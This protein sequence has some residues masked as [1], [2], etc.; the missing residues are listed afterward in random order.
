MLLTLDVGNTQVYAGIYDGDTIRARF[1]MMTG[2]NTSSDELGVFLRQAL[3]E[4]DI[5]PALV[6]GVAVSS[7]VPAFTRSIKNC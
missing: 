1:R 6:H 3:R 4:N 5:D 2:N 7:V